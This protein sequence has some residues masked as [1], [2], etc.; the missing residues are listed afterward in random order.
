MVARFDWDEGNYAKCQSHG[1]SIP[2]IEAVFAAMPR[3]APTIDPAAIEQRF[4]A[5]GRGAGDRPLFAVFTLRRSGE[6][7][8]IRPISARYMHSKEIVR[9]EQKNS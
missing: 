5:A 8:T 6:H 3:I 4:I 1:L 9:Y 2:E 7:M